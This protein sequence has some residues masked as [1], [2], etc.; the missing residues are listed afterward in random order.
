MFSPSCLGRGG[1]SQKRR[2]ILLISVG[3]FHLTGLRP[4][5][6][7]IEARGGSA[8]SSRRRG[9]PHTGAA[10]LRMHVAPCCAMRSRALCLVA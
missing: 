9:L 3:W 4:V 5:P 7:S 1:A 6:T 8:A 2:V 10:S